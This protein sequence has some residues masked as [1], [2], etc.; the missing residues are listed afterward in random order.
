MLIELLNYIL[1]EYPRKNYSLWH[2][3]ANQ[4]T[5]QSIWMSK[6]NYLDVLC[7]QMLFEIL[8]LQSTPIKRRTLLTGNTS[9]TL[10]VITFRSWRFGPIKRSWRNLMI[11][12]ILLLPVYYNN[13]IKILYKC[14]ILM[15]PLYSC[16]WL[17]LILHT[18]ENISYYSLPIPS[19][20]IK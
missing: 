15:S 8:I 11:S 4:I 5:N 17:F 3:S 19:S 7:N 16:L 13:D 14:S 1:A 10:Y 12:T 18:G 9:Y 6:L 20:K 2:S